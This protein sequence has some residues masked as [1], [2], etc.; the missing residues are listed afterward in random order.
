[1]S[2]PNLPPPDPT[3]YP[4]SMAREYRKGNWTLQETL[5]LITAKKL[6]DERRLKAPSSSSSPSSNRNSGELRWKWVENYCWSHGCLRSQNQCNDKWDNLLRDYK[7]VRDYEAT[8]S[9][10]SSSHLSNNNQFQFQSYWTMEKHQRKEHKLPSNMLLQVYQ[11]VTQV[12]QKKSHTSQLHH[13]HQHHFVN[14]VHSPPQEHPQVTPLL[15]STSQPL[16]QTTPAASQ[17]LLLLPPPS[18]PP[19]P[20]D[21]T[22]PPVSEGSESSGTECKN[23]DENSESKRRKFEQKLGSSIM[24][25]ASELAQALRS[26]EEKKEKRHQEMMELHRRGLHIEE[27]R[28]QV[29][30]QGITNLVSAVTNLTGVIQSFITMNKD[31]G[32]GNADDHAC[33]S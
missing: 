17:P 30:Q 3:F 9:S 7:K 28:N 32:A 13:H 19:R 22:T 26:C 8:K 15:T 14:V 33:S 10:S 20:V 12:L 11:A 2:E 6:D 29:N 4:S 25:S 16:S 21:S 5:I 27:T 24:R 31:H 1:M 18:L 23:D